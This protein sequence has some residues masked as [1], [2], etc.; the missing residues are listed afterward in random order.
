MKEKLKNIALKI[1]NVFRDYPVTLGCIVVIAAIAAVIIDCDFDTEYCERVILFLGA[2]SVQALFTE[3]YFKENMKFRIIGYAVAAPV[4]VFL[5]Y[6]GFFK[7]DLLFGA[8]TDKV[9]EIIACIYGSYFACLVLASVYHMYRR[10]KDKFET[11]CLKAFVGVIRTTVVYGLFAGG[12]AIIILIFDELIFKTHGFLGR[13]EIFLAGGIYVP[14]LLLVLSGA[15]EEVGKFV[16]IVVLYVLEPMLL[17]AMAIIYIYI[18]KIFVTGTIPSNSVFAIITS[19]F[20]SGMVIWTLACGTDEDN[21]FRKIAGILPFVFIPCILLQAWSVLIRISDYGF[22]PPRYFGIVLVIF[23]LIYMVLYF[24]GWKFEKDSVALIIWVT[25]L[26]VVVV[27]LMPFINFASVC[28]RSQIRRLSRITVNESLKDSDLGATAGSAYRC[29]TY[30]C[31]YRGE[32][33]VEKIYTEK[34]REILA[35]CY[36]SYGY[37]VKNDYYLSDNANITELDISEYKKLTLVEGHEDDPGNG[38]I[39]LEVDGNQVFKADLSEFLTDIREYGRKRANSSQYISFDLGEYKTLRLDEHHD[40]K[41]TRFGA[42]YIYDSDS[43]EY[44]SLSGYL[45]ER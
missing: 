12:L 43:L 24:I 38:P 27:L 29:L 37:T 5:V 26:T 25:A 35:S 15:K 16:R 23:E 22:T 21:I 30:D 8:K 39:V 6:I 18:I 33:A 44:L 9:R 40:L 36:G 10:Q 34:E 13:V 1:G 19:L 42:T 2:F 31:G 3:E 41:L 20:V 14:A 45:L 28:V 4:S 17:L 32:E 7:G 11:F